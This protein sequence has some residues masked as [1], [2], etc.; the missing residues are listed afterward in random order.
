M[1]ERH[2][3]SFDTFGER[4]GDTDSN[5]MA[6]RF[7]GFP[8][9]Q[10]GRDAGSAGARFPQNTIFAMLESD[11]AIYAC[12]LHLEPKLVWGGGCSGE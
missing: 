1:R 3:T 2:P 9:T 8:S 5:F 7:S 6:A 11:R 10:Q 12:A 4:Y